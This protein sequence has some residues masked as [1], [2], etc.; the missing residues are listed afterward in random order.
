[1]SLSEGRIRK[2]VTSRSSQ[3]ERTWGQPGGSSFS[4]TSVPVSTSNLWLYEYGK[5][6]N[7]HQGYPHSHPGTHGDVTLGYKGYSTDRIQ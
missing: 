5:Q 4:T 6:N 7:G 2:S 3:R 1:M